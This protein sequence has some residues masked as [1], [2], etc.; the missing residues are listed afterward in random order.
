MGYVKA[1]I[2]SEVYHL[3]K[4][5]HLPSIL[6]DKKI[7]RMGDSE[8]WFCESIEDM[9]RYMEYTVLNEG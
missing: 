5:A 7:K 9:K 3:T 6:S 1:N 4:R 2:P 8:C